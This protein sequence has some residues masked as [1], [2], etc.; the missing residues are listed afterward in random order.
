M[1][2]Y[3]INRS[4]DS[5]ADELTLLDGDAAELNAILSKEDKAMNTEDKEFM[6]SKRDSLKGISEAL[7]KVLLSAPQFNY[8]GMLWVQVH[9]VCK[10]AVRAGM[11]CV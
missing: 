9:N 5:D 8:T 7:P 10:Y 3:D 6:W 4:S 1:F 2:H 11:P